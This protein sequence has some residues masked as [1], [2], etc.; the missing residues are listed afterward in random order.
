[1]SEIE[2]RIIRALEQQEPKPPRMYELGGGYYYR[3]YWMSC[4]AT[5]SRWQNY[6]DQCGQRILWGEDN[7]TKET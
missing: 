6:C 5:V 7:D 4:N 2:D 1:M 3:C